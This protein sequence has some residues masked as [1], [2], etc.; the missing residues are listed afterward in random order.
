MDSSATV[1]STRMC[2]KGADLWFGQFRMVEMPM[3]TNTHSWQCSRCHIA[4]HGKPSNWL[5]SNMFAFA[6]PVVWSPPMCMVEN[7][8]CVVCCGSAIIE[9]SS[10]RMIVYS[11]RKWRY[12][13][14]AI[15]GKLSPDSDVW[16]YSSLPI[17]LLLSTDIILL[18]THGVSP[19]SH[20]YHQLSFV[21]W[22]TMSLL[23]NANVQ[24]FHMFPNHPFLIISIV[25]NQ[26]FRGFPMLRDHRAYVFHWQN[27][28][29][30]NSPSAPWV[31]PLSASDPSPQSFGRSQS[32]WCQAQAT[33]GYEEKLY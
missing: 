15:V 26:P 8:N 21:A 30:K 16:S 22:L 29:S 20:Q 17:T 12:L 11:F 25:V 9:D 10:F 18:L 32:S 5:T 27:P 28:V 6:F 13:I 1:Y 23:Q 33:P 4:T 7:D 3:A 19:N 31:Q 24:C 2:E 14:I